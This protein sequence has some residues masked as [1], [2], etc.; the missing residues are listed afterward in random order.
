MPR[1]RSSTRTIGSARWSSSRYALSQER[2][3]CRPFR[4]VGARKHAPRR[5]VHASA[6]ETSRTLSGSTS[7]TSTGSTAI[8]YETPRWSARH[9][10]LQP[11]ADD[12][13][14]SDHLLE[15]GGAHDSH[16]AQQFRAVIRRRIPLSSPQRSDCGRRSSRRTRGTASSTTT[17]SHRRTRPRTGSGRRRSRQE[18]GRRPP[19]RRRRPWL[20]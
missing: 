14:Y 8:G 5:R 10:G 9:G 12:G 18:S 11:W 20:R 3:H 2:W 13:Y 16:L 17:R 7:A 15:P 19:R 6:G 4:A 1:I